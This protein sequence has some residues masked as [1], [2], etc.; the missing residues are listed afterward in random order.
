VNRIEP[1]KYDRVFG[2]LRDSERLLMERAKTFLE[3][4]CLLY[5]QD[6]FDA[7]HHGLAI[8]PNTDERA[9]K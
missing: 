6:R 1:L 9:T 8:K 4:R 7:E 2:H 3:D 5:S